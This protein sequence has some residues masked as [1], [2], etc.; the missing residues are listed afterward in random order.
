MADTRSEVNTD[1]IEAT[2]EEEI[3]VCLFRI[4][5]D[6]YAIPVE[7]LTEIII[8]QKL[9]PVPTTPGHVL[10]VINLRGSII[11]IVDIRPVLALP[12]Q[13]AS[14]QIAILKHN[15]ILLGIIVDAVVEVASVPKSR[16]LDI[17]PEHAMQQQAGKTRNRFLKSIIQRESGV[18]ALLDIN[19]VFDAIK[20]A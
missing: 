13:S 11:P 1:V 4:G 18:A 6:S 14:G 8:T 10:G 9:F 7:V 5:D 12:Q 20:L 2:T 3:R 16:F 17:P 15:H 19:K